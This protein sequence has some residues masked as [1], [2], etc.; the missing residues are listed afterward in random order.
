MLFVSTECASE[1]ICLIVCHI[2]K[3]LVYI[4]YI[5]SPNNCFYANLLGV[6]AKYRIQ[7]T[8]NLNDL[9]RLHFYTFKVGLIVGFHNCVV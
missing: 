3:G 1:D 8:A 6:V 7:M 4:V 9:L 5:F 2:Y